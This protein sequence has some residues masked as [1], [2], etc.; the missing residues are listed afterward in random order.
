[1]NA[2]FEVLHAFCNKS[3]PLKCLQTK[4][5]QMLRSGEGQDKKKFAGRTVFGIVVAIEDGSPFCWNHTLYFDFFMANFWQQGIVN[6]SDLNALMSSV[7]K[8][9]LICLG[10]KIRICKFNVLFLL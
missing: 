5:S 8:L 9:E 6:H 2:Y 3:F 4:K 1:M 7:I 10:K